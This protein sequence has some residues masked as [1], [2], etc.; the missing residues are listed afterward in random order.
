V[1]VGAVISDRPPMHARRQ[2]QISSGHR[3][4]QYNT[5]HVGDAEFIEGSVGIEVDPS[6]QSP[7]P[8]RHRIV[9]RSANADGSPRN[10]SG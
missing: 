6:V 8:R 5:V 9:D 7:R 3:Y 2:R 1:A 4:G 10:L